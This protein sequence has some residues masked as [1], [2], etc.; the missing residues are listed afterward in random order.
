MSLICCR[1]SSTSKEKLIQAIF[2]RGAPLP[3]LQSFIGNA[4]RNSIQFPKGGWLFYLVF[5]P[6]FPSVQTYLQCYNHT[7]ANANNSQNT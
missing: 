1:C 4:L 5:T 2:P 7:M 3:V 6:S